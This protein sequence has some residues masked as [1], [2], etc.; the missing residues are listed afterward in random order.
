M[1]KSAS[2]FFSLIQ[3][4]TDIGISLSVEKDHNRLLEM[5]IK[6]AMELTN[7]DGGTIYTV[8]EDKKLKFEILF[9]NSMGIHIGG[10]S[11][12][13]STFSDLSLYDKSGK[14]NMAMA[15]TSAAIKKKTYVIKDAYMETRFDLSGTK[16]FDHKT[17]YHS[18]SFLVIPMTN[19]LNEV[20]G[21]LQLIN[22]MDPKT[23]QVRP[24]SKMDQIITESFASQAAIIL[25]NRI[26]IQAQK[27]LFDALIQLIA[28]A[29]DEKSPYT[30]EH[31]RRVPIIAHMVAD[32]A[33]KTKSGPLKNFHLTDDE[34][35]ELDVA[36]WLHDC[37]KITIPESV[38][39]KATK[40]ETIID[41]VELVDL[42][43][44]ILKRDATINY[45]K[46]K[47]EELTGAKLDLDNNK[48]LQQPL[49]KLDEERDFI[50]TCNI[51]G[52]TIEPETIQTLNEVARHHWITP[53]G[54]EAPLL[55]EDEI[56]NLKIARGTLSNQERQVINNHVVVSIKMLESLPY[57]KN[58]KQVPLLAGCHHEK[59]NGTGYPR[60][61]TRDQMP[62]QARIIA[63]A[64]VFEALT[65][66]ARPYKKALNLSQALTI[67]GKMK[68]DS[69]IDPDLFD[70]FIHEKV[71]QKF[72]NK[73]LDK[74]YV[75][76]IDESQIPGYL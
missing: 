59:M 43:F 66:G 37:G 32:A 51:G 27:E 54:E 12:H 6:K 74:K 71:Y 10:M 17:G 44:E 34:M 41:G 52:E 23:K 67:M 69:H 29:I 40:L 60:G 45:L 72:A 14:P 75:D 48:V 47:I 46:N 24:F 26:L 55:F 22:A 70:V 56:N 8:T 11:K 25:S 58:L 19:H 5:I 33:C 64:D 28:K 31:C 13:P 16:N 39:D 50:R 30:G 62:V 18:Q 2:E 3:S 36:A 4:L 57:P 49:K 20:I 68:L 73:F 65:S 42:R 15:A 53:S 76:K 61:L 9:N 7:A 35:Y 63:I 1:K 21:V 38:V